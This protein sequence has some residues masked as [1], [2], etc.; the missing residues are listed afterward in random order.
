MGVSDAISLDVPVTLAV[1]ALSTLALLGDFATNPV[2]DCTLASL[3]GPWSGSAPTQQVLVAPPPPP[4]PPPP[5]PVAGRRLQAAAAG[6]QQQPGWDPYAAQDPYGASDPYA[7]AQSVAPVTQWELAEEYEGKIGCG[8]NAWV[9]TCYPHAYYAQFSMAFLPRMFAW[10]FGHTGFEEYKV[11]M[12]FMLVLGAQAEKAIAS[13]HIFFLLLTT[14]FI[15]GAFALSASDSALIGSSALIFAVMLVLP[16]V[17][18]WPDKLRAGRGGE[19]EATS[20]FWVDLRNVCHEKHLAHLCVSGLFVFGEASLSYGEMAGELEEDGISQM[21]HMLAGFL[22]VVFYMTVIRNCKCLE[23]SQDRRAAEQYEQIQTSSSTATATASARSP[24]D[25]AIRRQRRQ[26][27]RISS[28]ARRSRS[29]SR[30]KSR[31][32]S[33]SPDRKSSSRRRSSSR[34]EESTSRSRRSSSRRRSRSRSRTRRSGSR[35]RSRSRSRSPDRRRDRDD[36]DDGRIAFTSS[37]K[38]ITVSGDTASISKGVRLEGTAICKEPR[39][40]SGKHY[41]EFTLAKTDKATVGVVRSDFDPERTKL[42]CASADGW[43]YYARIGTL[44]H[45]TLRAQGKWVG[46]K[47]AR[48]GAVIG[49]LLDCARGS[50]TCYHNGTRSG[51][52][53]RSGL[54]SHTLC[55]MVQLT[56]G[57]EVRIEKKEPPSDS[58][59]TTSSTSALSSTRTSSYGSRYGSSASGESVQVYLKRVGL[60]AWYLPPSLP[61]PPARLPARLPA[62][63]TACMPARLAGWLA[64][65]LAAYLKA[66][67]S[68]PSLCMPLPAW[69]S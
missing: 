17:R 25:K 10:S 49:L 24:K 56:D 7:P 51:E 13:D 20:S 21:G 37:H 18:M 33:R 4:P 45:N 2:D 5:V 60:E 28:S 52:L 44:H 66:N 27:R 23:R 64:G 53:V 11:N 48:E 36:V 14:S 67:K 47:S 38:D 62:C 32:R 8:L 3:H 63:L 35:S 30:S 22:G 50:L 26:R 65:C 12:L 29:R 19:A 68:S 43:G 15:G 55:W 42:A 40:R 39:M 46:Q 16:A 6:Q 58:G 34:A 1:V 31:S 59:G 9:F 41:V 57:A 54:S 61:S 69:G